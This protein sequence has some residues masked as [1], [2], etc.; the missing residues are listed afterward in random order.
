MPVYDFACDCGKQQSV[1]IGISENIKAIVCE[2]GEQMKRV[3]SA[4]AVTFKGTGW[5]KD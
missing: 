1:T 3:Y 4:P 2:C 5:G